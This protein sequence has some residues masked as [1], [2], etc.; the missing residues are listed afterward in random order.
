MLGPRAPSALCSTAPATVS[1][2]ATHEPKRTLGFTWQRRGAASTGTPLTISSGTFEER[3]VSSASVAHLTQ[4]DIFRCE[5]LRHLLANELPNAASFLC[6]AIDLAGTTNVGAKV[7]AKHG[8]NHLRIGVIDFFCGAGGVSTGLKQVATAAEF[9]IVEGLDNDPHCVSTYKRMVGAPCDPID[10]L[11]LSNDPTAL[12]QKIESWDLG[13]FDRVLLVGCSPCQGFSAHRKSVPGEDARRNLF[14]AFC[15]IVAA[16][17][18][19]GVLMENVPDLFSKSHW[20]HFEAGRS[21]LLDAGYQVK[22]GIYNF[23]G[24]GL[25]QERFRAVVMAFR[26]AFELPNAPLRPYQYRTV[27]DAIGKL[28]PLASGERDPDDPMHVA[29]NHRPSTIDILRKVPKNGGNRPMRVGPKCLD[30]TRTAHGGYTD[31][32]GRLAWDRPSVTV[33]ARCRT[34]SCGRFAHPEQDR[35]LTTREAALLQGFPPDYIFDGPFDDGF[36]QVGNAVSPV[37][38][39]HL[40]EFVATHFLGAANDTAIEGDPPTQVSKAIG[41]GFAVTIP[42]LKRKREQLIAAE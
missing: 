13:R 38:A 17:Q 18:P 24:F 5:R 6:V 29:S 1:A 7:S 26:D 36:K 30:R 39:R 23:A 10:I 4:L 9:V 27:R 35:G 33:T 41:P 14:E 22:S 21:L 34:P 28:L 40:G 32:Y 19:D 15:R 3:R 20:P 37:V 11:A 42:G 8:G 16:V 31:V 12:K 2:D 25:P